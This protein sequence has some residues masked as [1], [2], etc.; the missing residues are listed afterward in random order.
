ML[1]GP[2]AHDRTHYF[3][4][5]GSYA[6]PFGLTVGLVGY[7]RSGLPL[8][9][10]LNMMGAYMY[11]NNRADLGRLPFT[12]WG[13]LY[14]EYN[15]RLASKYNFQINLTIDNITN[16]STW[17]A[18][19]TSPIWYSFFVTDDDILSKSLELQELL[20]TNEANPAFGKYLSQF[21]RWWARLGFRLSF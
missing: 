5:F 17:Q 6:F 19:D 1:D 11:P 16:T 7:G 21:D 18:K 4:A 15:M 2:L 9:T 13:N 3:K 12:V 8:T 14:L 20:Q 10:T